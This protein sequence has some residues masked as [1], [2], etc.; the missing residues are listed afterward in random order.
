M[1]RA[2]RHACT[3]RCSAGGGA[4]ARVRTGQ[5]AGQVRPNDCN[6][7]KLRRTINYLYIDE[8]DEYVYAGALYTMHH[9]LYTMMRALGLRW[10]P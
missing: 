9:A 10:V 1:A 7:G 6:L 5:R 2:R 4:T 8:D 3:G